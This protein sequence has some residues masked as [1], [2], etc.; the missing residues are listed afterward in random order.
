MTVVSLAEFKKGRQPN[1]GDRYKW[2]QDVVASDYVWI[3]CG[4][5]GGKIRLT[6]EDEPSCIMRLRESDLDLFERQ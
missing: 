3:F 5:E 4:R 6:R 1:V 2:R